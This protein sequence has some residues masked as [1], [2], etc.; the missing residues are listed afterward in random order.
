MNLWTEGEL[1][2]DLERG[3]KGGTK[4]N[5]LNTI[6]REALRVAPISILERGPK[7]GTKMTW[8]SLHI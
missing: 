5:D 4:M 8:Y 3:P 6:W 1:P 7:G 2:D